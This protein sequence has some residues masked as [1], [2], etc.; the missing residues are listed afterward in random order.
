[1]VRLVAAIVEATVGSGTGYPLRVNVAGAYPPVWWPAGYIPAVGDAIKVL[2]VDGIAVVHSPVVNTQ[3]PLTGTV[4]AVPANGLL[5]VDTVVGLLRCRYVGAA[6]SI[7]A[8]VRLDWQATAPWVWPSAA[9]AI[10]LPPPTG[11]GGGPVAPPTGGSGTLSVT[12]TDSGT[13][14]AQYANWTGQ[15]GLDLTQGTYSGVA[16]TG[17]WFYGAAPSQAAGATI[18]GLRLRLGARRRMGNYNSNL[19][20]TLWVTSNTTKP[21]GDT[22]RVAGPYVVQFAPN[23]G[24]TWVDIP[25][26]WAPQIIAGGGIAIAGGS[27]GGMVGIGTDPASGQLQIDWTR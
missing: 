22:T 14:N 8:L 16:Y 21:A 20:V 25:L 26:S 6:P 11:T 9:A 2:M 18:T 17:A 15:N 27:Y 19:D 24:A 10:G 5:P 23:A 4:N 12:A 3:R 13:Y 1:V 7:G